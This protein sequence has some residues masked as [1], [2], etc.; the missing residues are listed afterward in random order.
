MTSVFGLC[1]LTLMLQASYGARWLARG[2]VR[3][4]HEGLARY[5]GRQLH[6]PAGDT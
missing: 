4:C 3:K 2:S 1:V 5:E 6:S